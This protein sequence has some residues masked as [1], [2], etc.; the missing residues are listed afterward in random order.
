GPSGKVIAFEPNPT[1]VNCFLQGLVKNAFNSVLLFPVA[2]SDRSAVF[3]LA[4]ASNSYLNG[5]GDPER[6]TQSIRGDDILSNEPRINVV[7]IDVEGHEP[8]VI[9]GVTGTLKR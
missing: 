9:K 8:F 5:K 7:K 2:L 4:G 6:L 3:S 1:N